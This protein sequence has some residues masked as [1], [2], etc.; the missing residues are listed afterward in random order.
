MHHLFLKL[1]SVLIEIVL[2]LHFNQGIT[3][4]FYFKGYTPLTKQ[5][6]YAACVV[7][8]SVQLILY[9]IVCT[10]Y[11]AT[12]IKLPSPHWLTNSLFSL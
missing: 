3:E 11:A 8:V 12:P 2:I 4:S 5:N 1:I 10:I 7:D 6:G 9:V